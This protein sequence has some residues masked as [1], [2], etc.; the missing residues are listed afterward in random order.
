MKNRTERHVSCLVRARSFSDGLKYE[1]NQFF[2]LTPPSGSFTSWKVC[3][4]NRLRHF[5]IYLVLKY[6]NKKYNKTELQNT[7]KVTRTEQCFL[8]CV[9]G[10]IPKPSRALSV[11]AF[12]SVFGFG[13]NLLLFCVFRW[14]FCSVFCFVTLNHNHNCFFLVGTVGIFILIVNWDQ[15]YDSAQNARAWSFVRGLN[16]HLIAHICHDKAQCYH[17]LLL[18][19]TQVTQ[20]VATF[21]VIKRC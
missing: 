10:E 2:S 20:S 19:I 1:G 6:S 21:G 14:F 17:S 16:L 8:S 9:A 12:I 3:F 18:E 15:I 7:K 4:F 13:Q 5:P 11:R